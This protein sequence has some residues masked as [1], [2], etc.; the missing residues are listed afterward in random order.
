MALSLSLRNMI[1]SP[2]FHALAFGTV[3]KTMTIDMIVAAMEYNKTK[4][5]F[6][7]MIIVVYVLVFHNFHFRF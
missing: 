6:S 3:N 5:M 1:S 2:I 4:V 7:Q